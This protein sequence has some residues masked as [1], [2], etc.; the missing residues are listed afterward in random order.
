MTV[1][2][3]N[4]LEQ[5]AETIADLVAAKLAARAERKFLSREEYAQIHGLG[6][7]TIDRAIAEGRLTVERSGR[8]VMIPANAKIVDRG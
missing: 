5:L 2:D 1:L 6:M 8:R 3:E 4:S 7:R